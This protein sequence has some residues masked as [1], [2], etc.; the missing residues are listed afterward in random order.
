LKNK[1]TEMAII[2][3]SIGHYSNVVNSIDMNILENGLKLQTQFPALHKD[4]ISRGNKSDFIS[5]QADKNS[6]SAA[7]LMMAK[8]TSLKGS[9]QSDFHA[10]V[11]ACP[12]TCP[13]D[14]G[15]PSS[16][17]WRSDNGNFWG[18]VPPRPAMVV[19]DMPPFRKTPPDCMFYHQ[20]CDTVNGID[21]DYLTLN[22]QAI[23]ATALELAGV[24]LATTTTTT[25]TNEIATSSVAEG[26]HRA[27]GFFVAILTAFAFARKP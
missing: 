20:A 12:D 10:V 8:H 27:A 21:W 19:N 24:K 14:D 26:T 18:A 22:T 1:K 17:F 25:T 5:Y 13:R 2:L 4:I 7:N 6:L 15:S 9:A 16:N 3:D 11:V 23:V